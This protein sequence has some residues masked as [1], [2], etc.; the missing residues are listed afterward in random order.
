MIVP[1]N[2]N[3]TMALCCAYIRVRR[4]IYISGH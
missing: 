3:D 4:Q 1:N 2:K